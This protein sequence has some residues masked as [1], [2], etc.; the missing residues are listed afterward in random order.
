MSLP[1]YTR[2][3][4]YLA[5]ELTCSNDIPRRYV[6]RQRAGT[7]VTIVFLAL[8]AGLFLVLWL[9]GANPRPAPTADDLVPVLPACGQAHTT[10]VNEALRRAY[11]QRL[12]SLRTPTQLQTD[13]PAWRMQPSEV[14]FTT[15]VDWM[16]AQTRFSGEYP[17]RTIE[18]LFAQ[19]VQNSVREKID[20]PFALAT[21]LLLTGM[22]RSPVTE[23]FLVSLVTKYPNPFARSGR[24]GDKTDETYGDLYRK[25][26]YHMTLRAYQARHELKLYDEPLEI[27][28]SIDSFLRTDGP[29]LLEVGD[30][31]LS[32]GSAVAGIADGFYRP[33]AAGVDQNDEVGIVGRGSVP[34]GLLVATDVCAPAWVIESAARTLPVWTTTEHRIRVPFVRALADLAFR[35]L[36]NAV[37][38]YPYGQMRGGSSGVALLRFR[39]SQL[40]A[41][42][43]LAYLDPIRYTVGEQRM[44]DALAALTP[45]EAQFAVVTADTV[46]CDDTTENDTQAPVDPGDGDLLR[47]DGGPT[48]YNEEYVAR[49][50]AEGFVLACKGRFVYEQAADLPYTSAVTGSVDDDYLAYN[51][52]FT[53]SYTNYGCDY[54]KVMRDLNNAEL[55]VDR[56]PNDKLTR[57]FALGGQVFRNNAVVTGNACS[58]VPINNDG[59]YYTCTYADSSIRVSGLLDLDHRVHRLFVRSNVDTRTIFCPF[60]WT[61]DNR[62]IVRNSLNQYP[63]VESQANSSINLTD[64]TMSATIETVFRSET[65]GQ[66]DDASSPKLVVNLASLGGPGYHGN[67]TLRVPA[68]QTAVITVWLD[69]YDEDALN[70]T[71]KRLSRI[72][73]RDVKFGPPAETVIAPASVNTAN[74]VTTVENLAFR[75]RI[76]VDDSALV[77]PAVSVESLV[78]RGKTYLFK[79]RDFA[80]YV[81][82]PATN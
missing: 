48:P 7:S 22:R 12:S 39:S 64:R 6:Q 66:P 5:N 2:Q 31:S 78:Y 75:Q 45:G 17:W 32:N 58:F 80:R 67:V 18:Y 46:P 71:S 29:S 74:T 61:S 36:Y 60:G 3:T 82:I 70:H 19:T 49:S 20:L 54:A 42:Y 40:A 25:V 8:L 27:A 10:A 79:T 77:G 76:V 55:P 24:P 63:E 14:G 57:G 65:P 43:Y 53:R 44:L 13:E 23:R 34:S 50:R 15:A 9:T 1:P 56:I 37:V 26:A 11:S 47:A 41:I 35:R 16:L 62:L 4:N 72:T 68:R 73:K 81:V 21:C 28:D 69:L 51:V 33:T 30:T 52:A 38:R 59:L